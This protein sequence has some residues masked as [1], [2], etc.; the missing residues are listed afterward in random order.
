M[1][2]WTDAE[3]EHIIECFGTQLG[4]TESLQNCLGYSI[5]QDPGPALVVYP[6]DKLAEFASE[7]RLEPMILACPVLAEKYDK[8]ASDKL[9]LQFNSMYIALGGAN[10]PSGL[11]SRPIRYLI[12]DEIDKFPKWSGQEA[13]PLALSE[14]RTK[15]FYNR[16]IIDASTPTL[17]T[18][19]IWQMLESADRVMKFQIP[20]P[21]C[22]TYQELRFGQIKFPKEE[23]WD[24]QRRADAAYYECEY[25]HGSVDDQ[26]K[27]TALKFGKWI[28]GRWDVNKNEWVRETER[29]RRVST[30]AFH[31]SSLYSPWLTWSKI[32]YEFLTSKDFPEKL[33][34]F[35]NSWLAEPWEDKASRM[36]SDVVEEMTGPN[37]RGQVPDEAQLLIASVD[38][39]KDHFYWVVRAWGWE[40][41]S[42]GVAYGRAETWAEIEEVI[43]RSYPNMQGEAVQVNLVGID[44]GY[45]TDEVYDFCA[46]RFGYCLPTKGNSRPM[47]SRYQIS[48]IEKGTAAGLRL[49]ILDTGQYKDM[50]FGRLKKKPGEPGAWMV[51]IGVEREYCDQICSEQK[52]LKTDKKGRTHEEWQKISSHAQNHYLDAE[53]INA[54]MA[55]VAGV[56]YLKRPDVQPKPTTAQE[57]KDGF[58]PRRSGWL[59]GD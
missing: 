53:V 57:A 8:R 51:P 19:P 11:A 56:R 4:K 32:V 17:K 15:T 9:E 18:G 46:K 20:C 48:T 49:Y 12:R 27:L 50:I 45:N 52:V 16:K 23:G 14:E 29:P 38:V 2:A 58:I 22:G 31:L 28:P 55:E 44:S 30:V 59:R 37:P 39:Q 34:N 26:Q 7:N 3:I 43:E 35:V 5:H 6:T 41:T 1:D 42:W 40:L 54:A 47:R 21:H 36:R 13:N 33:M 10:S 25:C 24:A